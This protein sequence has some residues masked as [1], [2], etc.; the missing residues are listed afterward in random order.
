MPQGFDPL[1]VEIAMQ[2]AVAQVDA[3][4]STWRPDSDLMHLNRGLPGQWI[5]VQ[6]HLMTVLSCA[7][8]VGRASD[9]AFDINVGDAVDAWGFGSGEASASAI[10]DAL[11]GHRRPAHDLLELDRATGQVRKHGAMALDLSGIAK[12]YGV[13]RLTQ[14]AMAFDIPGALLAIDGDLRAV[15]LRPDGSAWTVAIEQ[16]CY[17]LRAPHSCLDLH[18]AAAATSGDYRHWVEVDG[19]RLSHT[20]DPTRGGPL[21][22]SPAS[23][24]V[25]AENCMVADAWATALMVRGSLDGAVLARRHNLDALFLERRGDRFHQASSGRLFADAC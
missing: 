11:H 14:I 9:G 8:E 10:R 20:I 17:D 15:G 18:D 16:P 2:A 19:R 23:V 6:D 13:D 21:A 22:S 5:A 1:P 3:Q 12:G 24:T 25:I 4:M 7:A